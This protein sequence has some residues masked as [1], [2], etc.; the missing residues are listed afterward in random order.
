MNPKHPPGPAMT[1]GNS[2]RPV[3]RPQADA[4]AGAGE[5]L[6]RR[7]L[8]G[9]RIGPQRNRCRCVH[10]GGAP[11]RSET[12]RCWH[13][14]TQPKATRLEKRGLPKNP[15]NSN[16]PLPVQLE[17]A[18][19]INGLY[20]IGLDSGSARPRM[21]VRGLSGFPYRFP[22]ARGRGPALPGQARQGRIPR[23]ELSA[24]I[25]ALTRVTFQPKRPPAGS[26]WN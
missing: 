23:F 6:H 24:C 7:P 9:A 8:R 26:A 21:A 14:R 5:R 18:S 16:K 12:R 2:V 22:C 4:Q 20:G 10:G 1:L 11:L 3:Q 13:V 19:Y 15:F 17:I 25:F